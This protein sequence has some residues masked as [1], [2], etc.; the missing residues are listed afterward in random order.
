VKHFADFMG[1][2]NNIIPHLTL[3]NCFQAPS[4]I[5]IETF[6][7]FDPIL[8]SIFSDETFEMGEK[9]DF[10]FSY[11]ITGFLLYRGNC[12]SL[13][14]YPGAP[15]QYG[16]PID[17]MEGF[18]RMLPIICSW[19]S[20]GRE[21][22]IENLNGRKVD[23]EKIVKD[24]LMA[25]TDPD[26][27]G[28]WG[29]ISD[30]DQRICEAADLALSIWLVRDS[31]WLDIRSDQ[32]KKI[33]DWLLCVNGKKV[34]DNNWHLFPV[35]INEVT[36]ALG[37]EQDA[38]GV[39]AHYSRFK[40]FNKG[41]GW[42]S[43]GPKNVYDYYNAWA[44]YYTL[45]WVDRVNPEF[46]Q[47]FIRESLRKF[48]KYYVYL[49]SPQGIPI[50]GRSICYR[51]AA[52]VPLIAGHI[53]DPASVDAGLARR[54]L[55]SL[56]SYFISKGAVAQ[57]NV[58]QGY[59]KKDL[60]F[61]DNYSGPGSSLWALRSLV[62][63]FFCPEDSPLWTAT[64]NPLPIEI[65]DYCITIP[66][67]G[68][69]VTGFKETQEIIIDTGRLGRSHGGI[70]NYTVFHKIAGFLARRPFRPKNE[71]VKYQSARYSSKE[72]FCG[73]TQ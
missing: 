73:C 9:Y 11:F 40:S 47:D 29:D 28:Y 1:I 59:Y 50:L 56:W 23:L 10:L 2:F 24:G 3:R 45:F 30:R 60:R 17:S 69:T 8:T 61:L 18:T 62:L 13:V 31:L 67:I 22:I 5:A 41:D 63:A 34:W 71:L 38:A 52:S 48:L 27:P 49:L 39:Q 15:S 37:Y 68:W 14:S 26:S 35:M 66:S 70:K 65:A 21:K 54:A 46:D 36:A 20:S 55:D 64:P 51:M 19:L 53:Q 42:F 44:M 58:T 4:P 12:F 43:D 57:G 25:G 33:I 32:R 6:R 7:R 72:P 16:P